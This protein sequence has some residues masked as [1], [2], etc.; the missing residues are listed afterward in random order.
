MQALGADL[1][2]GNAAQ[3]TSFQ[4]ATGVTFPLMLNGSAGAGNENLYV[5]YGDRDSYAVIS[6]QGIVRYNAYN[7]W[8]YG[9]RFHLDEL[10]G[11]IDTLVSNPLGVEEQAPGGELL[12][13][14]PNPFQTDLVIAL[15]NPTAGAV[16]A[17]LTVHD[18]SGR[19]I[20]GLWSGT[21]SAGV[22]R[23]TW[24]ARTAAAGPLAAGVYLLRSD[25]GGVREVRRVVFLR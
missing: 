16:A 17:S 23:V 12:Q 8:P 21:L 15:R 3:L 5:P 2:N 13:A 19:R 6:K 18:L 14:T 7:L 11:C 25:I 22:T 1:F 4:S 24:N 9:N 10:R 20:A